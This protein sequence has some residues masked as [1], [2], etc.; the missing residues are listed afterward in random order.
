MPRRPSLAFDL[1]HHSTCCHVPEPAARDATV[2]H[3]SSCRVT[4]YELARFAQL[5]AAHGP[6]VP[7]GAASAD[8]QL[9]SPLYDLN[10][11][12]QPIWAGPLPGGEDPV[13]SHRP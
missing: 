12:T 10:T 5:R 1:A 2:H 11:A 13:A 7:D 6:T 8:P 9:A 3:A 4:K